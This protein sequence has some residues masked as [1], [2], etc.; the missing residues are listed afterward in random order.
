MLNTALGGGLSSRLFQQVRE[1]RGLAY[2]VYS[3]S[4]SL[5]RRGRLR[6]YAGCPPERLD[7]VVTVI[8][9][10]LSEVARDGITPAEVDRAKG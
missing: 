10:V 9:D 3:S 6:V 2:S 1:Q 5:L 8:R 7:E 4:V